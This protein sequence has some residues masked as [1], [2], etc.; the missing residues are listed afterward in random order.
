MMPS[1]MSDNDE[2]YSFFSKITEKSSKKTEKCVYS[3]TRGFFS[4]ELELQRLEL[5][6]WAGASRS[7]DPIYHYVMSWHEDERPTPEQIDEAVITRF[8]KNMTYKIVQT[9]GRDNL[10]NFAPEFAHFNDDILFTMAQY[11]IWKVIASV[12]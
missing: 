3:G 10:G 5:E 4:D 1:L 7:K 2:K 6:A 9:A 8:G 11:K 12:I